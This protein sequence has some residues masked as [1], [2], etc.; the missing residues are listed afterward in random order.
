MQAS[1]SDP[2]LDLAQLMR[3]AE[4]LTQWRPM[5]L[6]FAS[7]ALAGV[8]SSAA[9]LAARSMSG[10]MGAMLMLLGLIVAG[11]VL[12]AGYS[13][14]GVLL[15]DR[16]KRLPPRMLTDALIYGL[17]TLPR[18][19]GFG[20]LLLV[21]FLALT[22]TA[23]IVYF[24]CKIPV[25][26]P[27]LLFV[28]H[29][30]LVVAAAVLILSV[31]W[32]GFP[33]FAPAVWDGRGFKEAV[34]VVV[35]VARHRLLQVVLAL[36]G[37]SVVT[38]IV[39]MLVLGALMP[40]FGFMGALAGGILGA[41]MMGNGMGLMGLAMGVMGGDL[42]GGFA[43][44][45]LASVLIFGV[46]FTLMMQVMIMGANLAYLSVTEGLDL[47]AA[48]AAIEAGLAST[49][50]KAT[51]LQERAQRA[52]ERARQSSAA[53]PS[54]QAVSSPEASAASVCPQCGTP[55]TTEDAFCGHCGHR[56]G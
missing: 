14:V 25:L 5:A 29:P 38:G 37:A 51:E 8:I 19:V 55:A 22:L 30:V 56:L 39:G 45:A 16:A 35:A 2:K 43:A 18:F 20:L 6:G 49:R 27:L 1:P 13:G 36:L 17:M 28:A 9:M 12:A 40:G 54:Q 23:T 34:S 10:A 46:A 26:G 4:G 11:I 44:L 24:V 32:V 33:M 7:F 52:A 15:M 3:A 47:N 53:A 42:G 50:Q 31:T 41:S 21:V 48:Q